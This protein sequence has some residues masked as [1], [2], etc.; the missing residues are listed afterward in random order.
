MYPPSRDQFDSFLIST[1]EVTE[2]A[3][4]WLNGELIGIAVMDR[5]END[6]TAVYTFYDPDLQK[7]SLGVFAIL[8]QLHYANEKNLDHVYLGYWIK[9]CG[10]MNYKL[11][12]RPTQLLIDNNWL[13]LN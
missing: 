5:L 6:L 13:T 7:R 2:Y 11:N 9:E 8:W 12:Y 1:W 10:K 4:F 3:E